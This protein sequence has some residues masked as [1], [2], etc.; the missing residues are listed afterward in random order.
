VSDLLDQPFILGSTLD[1]TD[2]ASTIIVDPS[3]DLLQHCPIVQSVGKPSSSLPNSFLLSGGFRRIVALRKHFGDLYQ[4]T[5]RF[6]SM[7]ADAVLDDGNLATLH[8]KDQNTTPVPRSKKFGDV[9]HMDVI[10]G[11]DVAIGNICYGALF[12]DRYSHMTYLY[13][14]QNLQSDVQK[15]LEAFFAHIG[16]HPK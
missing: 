6:D 5:L 2:N 14:L 10:F 1:T 7:P 3:P 11:P 12:T 13:P 8:K 15:Q 4:N 16:M 9:I